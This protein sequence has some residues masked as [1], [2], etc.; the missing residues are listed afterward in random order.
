MGPLT[1]SQSE[2]GSPNLR[3][4]RLKVFLER[5][6]H[7]QVCHCHYSGILIFHFV[8][9]RNLVRMGFQP[10]SEDDGSCFECFYCV[11][12]PFKCLSICLHIVGMQYSISP[13]LQT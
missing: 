8:G 7:I 5:Q 10:E 3:P 9:I 4:T 1:G 12:L 13:I 2:Q 11:G 6:R